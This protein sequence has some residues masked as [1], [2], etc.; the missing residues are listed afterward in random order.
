MS[1][2]Y[3]CFKE[4]DTLQC[5]PSICLGGMRKT[6]HISVRGACVRAEIRKKAPLEYKSKLH[7]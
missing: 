3:Y 5:Y 7:R 2:W 6:T 4:S 1:K